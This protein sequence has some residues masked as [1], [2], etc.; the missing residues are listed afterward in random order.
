[1]KVEFLEIKTVPQ[2]RGTATANWHIWSI[3]KVASSNF[4]AVYMAPWFN[5]ESTSPN[6]SPWEKITKDVSDLPAH[7]FYILNHLLKFI[8]ELASSFVNS[9]LSTESQ[10]C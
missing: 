1:M 5:P 2:E 6:S 3:Y 4:A 7:A 8:R 9:S 10:N